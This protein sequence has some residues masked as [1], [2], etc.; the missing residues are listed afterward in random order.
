ML[1]SR[2]GCRSLNHPQSSLKSVQK[3]DVNYDLQFSIFKT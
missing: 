1:L 3:I 2:F